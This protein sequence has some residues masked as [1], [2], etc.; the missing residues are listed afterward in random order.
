MQLPR[1]V[2]QILLL[3]ILA[4]VLPLIYLIAWLSEAIDDRALERAPV[5][6]RRLPAPRIRRND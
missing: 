2:I 3:P 4:L 5:V 1:V 6:V